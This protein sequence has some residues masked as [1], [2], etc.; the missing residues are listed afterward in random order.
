MDLQKK[1]A[2]LVSKD[3]KEKTET[4]K[5]SGMLIDLYNSTITFGNERFEVNENGDLF[6][7]VTG[8]DYLI[9]K[10]TEN[11]NIPSE[12]KEQSLLTIVA[13]MQKTITTLQKEI[14]ELKK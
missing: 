12:W 5:G 14:K 3:Y 11:K 9:S 4:D 1:K 10:D 13:E 8:L 7:K 2:E 6:A